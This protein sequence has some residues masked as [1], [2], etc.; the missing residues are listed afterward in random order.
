MGE[1]AE[2]MLDGT[3]C[4]GCGVFLEGEGFPRYCSP[5][6][7]PSSYVDLKGTEVGRPACPTCDKRLR[8]E[9]GL[10][11]HIRDKHGE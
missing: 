1:I 2:M 3:I 11:Q 7:D 8:N 10:R 4:E 6:C 5:A 9:T